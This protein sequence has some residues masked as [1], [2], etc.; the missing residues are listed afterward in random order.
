[1]LKLARLTIVACLILLAASSL[2]CSNLTSLLAT[3]TPTATLTPTPTNTPTATLTPTDTPTPTVTPT[4]AP[5]PTPPP[6][7][8]INSLGNGWIEYTDFDT[9]YRLQLPD[10]WYGFEFLPQDLDAMVAS[11]K[12]AGAS[13]T[14]IAQ[15]EALQNSSSA[16]FGS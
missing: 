5:T 4:E 10:T 1:M 6:T 15:V 14:I 7:F 2:A 11:L 3:P 8:G 9:G 13:A 12:R 16:K